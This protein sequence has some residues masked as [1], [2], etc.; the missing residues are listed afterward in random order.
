VPIPPINTD[1]P[2]AICCETWF[3]IVED[4]TRL[5]G[6]A[7]IDCLGPTCG[8]FR[9]YV[10][11]GPPIGGGDYVAGWLADRS[12]ITT[13]QGDFRVHGATPFRT[14]IG[15]AVNLANFPG[16]QYADGG[17]IAAVPSAAEYMHACYFTYGAAERMWRAVA[18]EAPKGRSGVFGAC[19]NVQ[20]G[21]LVPEVPADYNARW[22]M[23]LTADI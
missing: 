7:V 14:T 10:S 9:V 3:S 1:Q 2:A 5:A 15:L 21:S 12:P 8:N 4:L 18:N 6:N 13:P 20:I 11:H 22:G 19:T 23:S 16:I 17:K